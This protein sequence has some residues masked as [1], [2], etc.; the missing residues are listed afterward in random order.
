MNVQASDWQASAT[1]NNQYFIQ[2][3]HTLLPD[4]ET[5]NIQINNIQPTSR[6]SLAST[7]ATQ[8]SSS[9][10]ITYTIFIPSILALGYNDA[11]HMLNFVQSTLQGSLVS[12]Q[13]I[14]I[15][16]QIVSSSDPANTLFKTLQSPSNTF[17]VDSS[18]ST[19]VS[20]SSSNGS[21][22]STTSII[23]VVVVFGVLFLVIVGYFM[24]KRSKARSYRNYYSRQQPSNDFTNMFSD[25]VEMESLNQDKF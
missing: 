16:Q 11:D 10:I 12:T 17:S 2:T 4:I 20:S 22:S 13:F 24:W 14:T 6:R 3:L 21:N 5:T 15:F 8:S 9:L 7:I 18:A 1:T 25:V 19:P 23:A